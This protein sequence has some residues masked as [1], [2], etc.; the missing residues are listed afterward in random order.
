MSVQSVS[1]LSLWHLDTQPITNQSEGLHSLTNLGT[2][3]ENNKK[4]VAPSDFPVF[5]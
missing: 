4:I 3:N 5:K 1:V 2:V